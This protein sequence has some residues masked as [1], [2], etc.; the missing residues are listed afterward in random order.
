MGLA[1]VEKT[2]KGFKVKELMKGK[3]NYQFDWEVKGVRKGYE[4]Y[5]V[6]R[7]KEERKTASSPRMQNG[8]DEATPIPAMAA[9]SDRPITPK[10]KKRK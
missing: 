4:D 6:V 3:G 8:E 2:E 5:K 9:P 7:D 10:A 1:V